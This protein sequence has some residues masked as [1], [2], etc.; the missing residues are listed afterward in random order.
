ME[1]IVCVVVV[2][3]VVFVVSQVSY[4]CDQSNRITAHA[5]WADYENKRLHKTVK[6]IQSDIT[7]LN[8]WVTDLQE[9]DETSNLKKDLSE[10]IGDLNER[11]ASLK[12][13]LDA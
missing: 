1:F 10:T 2:A 12:E 4:N 5:Q 11:L 3:I 9:S 6:D 13:L 8:R 7:N